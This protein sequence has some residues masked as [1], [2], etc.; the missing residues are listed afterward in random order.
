MK[1][2]NTLEQATLKETFGNILA[3]VVAGIIRFVSGR[4]HEDGPS[5]LKL[6]PRA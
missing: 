6:S 1:Y 4:S 5:P 3:N 2:K